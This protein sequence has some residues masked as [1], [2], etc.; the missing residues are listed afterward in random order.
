[1]SVESKG[2]RLA[3]MEQLYE[4]MLPQ[5]EGGGSVRLTVSGS[6]MHP[7]LRHRLDTVVLKACDA[8]A[9]GDLIFYRREDG[10]FVLHRIVRVKMAEEFVC[11]GDNQY[12]PERVMRQQ[13]I[14]KMTEFTRA[15]K[16]YRA[17]HAGYRL[18]VAIWVWM[19]PVR[20]PF[21]AVRRMLGK[22]RRKLLRRK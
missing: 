10:R 9:R 21:L 5:L 12:E 22:L 18:Y 13:V 8:V 20:R 17:D 1:M 11:S 4:L 19:F 7:M 3:P 6:S 2:I 16:V 15:G 14:A